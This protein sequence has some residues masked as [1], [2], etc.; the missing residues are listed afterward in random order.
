MVG[1]V[2]SGGM[3]QF[4]QSKQVNADASVSLAQFLRSK[5]VKA[6]SSVSLVLDSSNDDMNMTMVTDAWGKECSWNIT[7]A[8]GDLVCSGSGYPSNTVNEISDCDF[9]P[10]QQYNLT[11]MDSWGDG[12]GDNYLEIDGIKYC[13]N[14]GF[15]TQNETFGSTLVDTNVNCPVWAA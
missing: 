11:C 4:L 2:L 14:I 1:C 3:P 8:E 10:N 7:D 5:Q 6:V 13:N 9:E 15:S 12:W